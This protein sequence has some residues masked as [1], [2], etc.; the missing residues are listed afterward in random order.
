VSIG[1]GHLGKFGESQ[2]QLSTDEMVRY[3]TATRLWDR[4]AAIYSMS[5]PR[6]AEGR[7]DFVWHAMQTIPAASM[8]AGLSHEEQEFLARAAA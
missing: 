5:L 6:W 2:R 4:G 1:A 8:M 3:D 7:A